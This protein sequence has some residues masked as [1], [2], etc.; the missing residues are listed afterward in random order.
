MVWGCFSWFWLGPLVPVKGNLNATAYNDILNDS[1]LPTLWQ[2]FW[3]GSFLFQHDNDPM[4]KVR[5]NRPTSVPNLTNAL[6]A[7]WK[8]VLTAMFQHLVESLPNKILLVT[9]TCVRV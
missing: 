2:H 7:Q 8:Q 6:V 3:E 9:Y 1:V 4:H 5:S